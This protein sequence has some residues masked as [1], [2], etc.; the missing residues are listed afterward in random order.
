MADLQTFPGKVAPAVEISS[1]LGHY[2]VR[3]HMRT[4][5]ANVKSELISTH[6]LEASEKNFL[7]N[8][9]KLEFKMLRN[10][11]G[12]QA[13]LKLQMERAM[14]SKIQRLPC[15]PSSMIALDTLM[16]TDE[17]IGFEDF[18]NVAGDS[19]VTCDPHLT[20][21]YKLGLH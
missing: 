18:L 11:Q 4:G 3:D 13:P 20:M 2:G 6:P 19:E 12:L 9:E 1:S 17:C 7:P 21:E 14:A 15:L 5:F 8:Q 16:G 10:T